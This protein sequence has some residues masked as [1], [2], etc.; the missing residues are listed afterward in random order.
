MPLFNL[1]VTREVDG[2]QDGIRSE[3][4][5]ATGDIADEV[6]TVTRTSLENGKV[7]AH[8]VGDGGGK[9]TTHYNATARSPPQADRIKIIRERIKIGL[10]PSTTSLIG[11]YIRG[12]V[13]VP[14]VCLFISISSNKSPLARSRSRDRCC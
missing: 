14:A 11:T 10:P 12:L 5:S 1:S 4:V 9:G 3:S 2:I 6:T 8:G 13:P 7:W